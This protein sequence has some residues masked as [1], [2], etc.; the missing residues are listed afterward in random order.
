MLTMPRLQG[1]M[2]CKRQRSALLINYHRDRQPINVKLRLDLAERE[3]TS[4]R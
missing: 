4:L 2:V 3:A 1:S